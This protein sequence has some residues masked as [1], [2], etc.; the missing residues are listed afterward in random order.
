MKGIEPQVG[1]WFH[2]HGQLF[3]VVA[4]DEADGVIEMQ[5]ADGDIEEM[6]LDDWIIRA[7]TGGILAAEAPEDSRLAND[8]EQEDFNGLMPQAFE[9]L[10]GL[11]ADAL[12]DLDL[13]D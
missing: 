4:F 8:T 13:F 7:R 1:G 9:E 6:D 11:H 10:R 5:H 3:E 2:S 12:N